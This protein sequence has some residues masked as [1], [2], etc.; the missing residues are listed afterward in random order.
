[1]DLDGNLPTQRRVA[2]IGCGHVGAVTAACLAELGHQVSGVDL[3]EALIRGLSAGRA[4]FLEPGLDA[5]LARNEAD[6]RLRFTTSYAEALDGAE[7]LMLCVNTPATP[8][9][10]ADLTY[11]RLAV[12][13]AAVALAGRTPWPLLVTKSTSPIGTS[14][15]IEALLARDFPG[16]E[17]RPRVVANPEFLREG[18][19]VHD[20]FNPERL[21]VGAEAPADAE[22]VAS[23]YR[24][25]DAPCIRTD[26]R[27]AELI[28][29]AANAFLATRVSF[30]NEV[31]QLCER[32][33]ADVD[34]LV[35]GLSLDS[36]IGRGYLHPGIGYGGSC[37]PKDVAAL[38]HTGDTVGLPMRVLSAVQA[39]NLAQ[40]KQAVNTL[41][42]LLGG[43][44]GRRIAVWGATFKGETEDLRESPA[45]GVTQLLVNEGAR[46][47][48]Y[49][50]AVRPG[51]PALS[52]AVAAVCSD[53]LAAVEG[54]DC[55]AVLSDWREFS[56]VD[57]GEAR[58]RMAGD[59]VYDGRNLLKR[60]VVEAAG[61]RYHGVGRALTAQ[62]P[63]T[64][65]ASTPPSH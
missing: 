63:D 52:A 18:S 53:A 46:V 44:D 3:N 17:P 7:F 38:C 64:E 13:Q 10:A 48:L 62:P 42:A 59:L 37:L 36:R 31:A 25:I 32:L 51:G 26:F 61:L 4:P 65:V 58:R 12:T 20:F 29:Y 2:V 33:G 14:E 50:P 28:K 27:T 24:A 21:V 34:T 11:V 57:L 1:M 5:L 41:R 49:D 35:E 30:I 9:G 43:L 60:A 22:A 39:A 40:Q 54:A 8:L 19:A 16:G 6:G 56:E 15:T 55:L 23:L 45:L 47:Q